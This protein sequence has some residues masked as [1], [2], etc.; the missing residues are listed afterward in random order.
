MR[1]KFSIIVPVYQQWHYIKGLAQCLELQEASKEIFELILVSN[2][3]SCPRLFREYSY[4]VKIGQ[5][6]KLGAY[7]A[8]NEGAR[9][10]EGEWLVFTDA[11]CLPDLK[12][13][14]EIEAKVNF[15]GSRNKLIAGDIQTLTQPKLSNIFAI[16]DFVKG[17]PQE[18]YV[19]SG[20]AATANLT[21]EK[22]LFLNSGGFDE[23]LYSGGD[24]DLCRR[25][26]GLGAGVSF[27]K[28]AFVYHRLRSTWGAVA[29]KVRRVKGGQFIAC[30][31]AGRT[32]MIVLSFLPPLRIIYYLFNKRDVPIGYRA[33]AV[34]VQLRLW[35]V[36]IVEVIRLLLGSKPRRC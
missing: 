22:T 26:F 24:F 30:R 21:V 25:L 4:C 16:Y 35:G 19:S 27:L 7:A 15:P 18:V 11:D 10:A 9:L 13:I 2:D 23:E 29:A 17:I 8:R 34:L 3:N 33:L 6:L 1:V 5:C 20:V 36:E 32:K 31:D 12:W 28:S 14:S